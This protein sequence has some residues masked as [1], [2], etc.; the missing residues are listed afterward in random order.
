MNVVPEVLPRETQHDGSPF[1]EVHEVHKRI[2]LSSEVLLLTRVLELIELLL[3]ALHPLLQ[4]ALGQVGRS[5][6]DDDVELLMELL[7]VLVLAALVDGV[8]EDPV[9]EGD[10]EG[11]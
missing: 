4:L 2:S 9:E 1:G 3:H 7:D 11:P 10:D 6:V 8:P 5:V